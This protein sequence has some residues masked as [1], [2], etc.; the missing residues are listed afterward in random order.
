MALNTDMSHLYQNGPRLA[1]LERSS[2]LPTPSYFSVSTFSSPASPRPR[3][4]REPGHGMGHGHG[5]CRAPSHFV[6]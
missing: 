5:H 2:M 3:F 6:P 1:G 4:S